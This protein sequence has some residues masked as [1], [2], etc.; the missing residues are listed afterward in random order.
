MTGFPIVVRFP[1]HWSE[2]DALGH[3]NNARY[4]T[5]FETSRIALFDRVGLPSSGTPE[6]GPILARTDCNFLA[7][8]RYPCDVVAGTRIKSLG[9]T[10][11]TM[12]FQVALADEPNRPVAQG[13]G[14]VVLIDYSSG[15][16]VP[17]GADLR[18]AL[19]ALSTD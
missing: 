9:T 3:V 11:F 2:M 17:I 18:T 13:E 6:V 14:V 10:S 7:P 12:E 1:V 16:K 4:F 8:V 19:E 5:W 15:T